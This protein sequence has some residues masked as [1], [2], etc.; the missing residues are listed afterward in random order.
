MQAPKPALPEG[1]PPQS[2]RGA[3][4]AASGEGGDA[5]A[6]RA[7]LE[8]Q[9][10][11]ALQRQATEAGLDPKDIEDAEESDSPKEAFVELLVEW[12]KR[13]EEEEEE[14]TTGTPPPPP[15]A[16]AAAAAAAAPAAPAPAAAAPAPAPGSGPAAVEEVAAA[17]AVRNGLELLV[18]SGDSKTYA[19]TQMEVALT[20]IAELAPQQDW[21][22]LVTREGI[23]EHLLA[24]VQEGKGWNGV[25]G[26]KAP[27]EN[28][29]IRF[30]NMTDHDLTCEVLEEDGRVMV[31]KHNG[32]P[33]TLTARPFSAA[34]SQ[35]KAKSCVWTSSQLS[36]PGTRYR[37]SAGSFSEDHRVDGSSSQSIIV[38]EKSAESLY[39]VSSKPG[40]QLGKTQVW[41]MVRIQLQIDG[42][43]ASR[44]PDEWIDSLF[45]RYDA[46]N[47]GLIDDDEW[48]SM[49]QQL[50]GEVTRAFP[51]L[52]PSAERQVR[53]HKP[54]EDEHDEV[55]AEEPAGAGQAQKGSQASEP[56]PEPAS[57][58]DD[59]ELTTGIQ[60]W[61]GT[62]PIIQVYNK[63][64]QQHESPITN[65]TF[66][67]RTA[68]LTFDVRFYHEKKLSTQHYT[69]GP[70]EKSEP[71]KTFPKAQWNVRSTDGSASHDFEIAAEDG[72]G[73]TICVIEMA[74][75]ACVIGVSA[76]DSEKDLYEPKDV[77]A[78]LTNIETAPG[79]VAARVVLAELTHLVAYPTPIQQNATLN[80][81]NLSSEP[82]H[83]RV[84]DSHGKPTLPNGSG[85]KENT[86]QVP[87]RTGDDPLY[88]PGNPDCCS[89]SFCYAD[90]FRGFNLILR[91]GA[92]ELV[93]PLSG[94]TIQHFFVTEGAPTA[95][96]PSEILHDPAG[97]KPSVDDDSE[98]EGR[99]DPDANPD[100]E[101]RFFFVLPDVWRGLVGDNKKNKVLGVEL[102]ALNA[103]PL[104]L[105][106][107]PCNGI[108]HLWQSDP[109]KQGEWP[110]T[111]AGQPCKYRYRCRLSIST[112]GKINR[113]MQ[114][115]ELEETGGR[116]WR[117]A[118][119]RQFDVP[120]T[121]RSPEARQYAVRACM[122][123]VVSIAQGDDDTALTDA[124]HSLHELYTCFGMIRGQKKGMNEYY[125]S[126]QMPIMT[127][128]SNMLRPVGPEYAAAWADLIWNK[129]KA[130]GVSDTTMMFFL[131]AALLIK[132]ANHTVAED[133]I[134]LAT[135]IA[136]ALKDFS[137]LYSRFPES[138]K[139]P[140]ERQLHRYLSARGTTG[141]MGLLVDFQ[142]A[143]LHFKD[144]KYQQLSSD[145]VGRICPKDPASTGDLQYYKYALAWAKVADKRTEGATTPAVLRL[146]ADLATSYKSLKFLL[147]HTASLD[148]LYDV[149]CARMIQLLRDDEKIRLSIAA[150]ELAELQAGVLD[151]RLQHGIA[152]TLEHRLR[153][154]DKFRPRHHN[155]A[156]LTRTSTGQALVNVIADASWA[157]TTRILDHA[158]VRQIH[159]NLLVSISASRNS[160]V[161]DTLLKVLSA[162]TFTSLTPISRRE[163]CESW[164]ATAVF[165][166][167]WAG[168]NRRQDLLAVYRRLGEIRPR[169]DD[170]VAQH[171][172]S[173]A[174]KITVG[175]YSHSQYHGEQHQ[176]GIQPL[177]CFKHCSEIN[178]MLLQAA[179]SDDLLVH[180]SELYRTLI[181]AK[182]AD[183][184]T[185][186]EA[187]DVISALCGRGQVVPSELAG[188]CV[189][190]LLNSIAA[191][192]FGIHIPSPSKGEEREPWQAVLTA[193]GFWLRLMSLAGDNTAEIN[194]HPEMVRARGALQELAE[195]AEHS[196]LTI[197]T[198]RDLLGFHGV[199]K[200]ASP[201]AME[202][203]VTYK[204]VALNVDKEA[205]MKLWEIRSLIREREL[206]YKQLAHVFKHVFL[207]TQCITDAGSLST[208]LNKRKK[209]LEKQTIDEVRAGSYWCF[210]E[211]VDF[212]PIHTGVSD[213][214]RNIITLA[215]LCALSGFNGVPESQTFRRLCTH[216]RDAPQATV[217][218]F[219]E[220]VF[221]GIVAEYTTHAQSFATREYDGAVAKL[222]D[223]D[224]MWD[225]LTFGR[226]AAKSFTV[227]QVVEVEMGHLE[228]FIDGTFHPDALVHM[229]SYAD[230][231]N[232]Q[233]DNRAEHLRATTD[234]F[235]SELQDKKSELTDALDILL[236][237][238]KDRSKTLVA[239]HD[240]LET[241]KKQHLDEKLW[242]LVAEL[243][244]ATELVAFLRQLSD[245]QDDVRALIDGVEEHSYDQF[246]ANEKTV[247]NFI[248]VSTFMRPLL[249]DRKYTAEHLRGKTVKELQSMWKLEQ[250]Q[251]NLTRE[252]TGISKKESQSKEALMAELLTLKSKFKNVE[253]FLQTLIREYENVGAK[254]DAHVLVKDCAT[255]CHALRRL[256]T[257]LANRGEATKETVRNV[258]ERGIFKIGVALC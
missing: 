212:T 15:P 165:Q 247:K 130:V 25:E 118:L 129:S 74:K 203:S 56:A 107:S 236:G 241:V 179:L 54:L 226:G 30:W 17:D 163:I 173:I 128:R 228:K 199:E 231:K 184:G 158:S 58:P 81:W 192:E 27:Y 153:R 171:L 66:A 139:D 249:L 229:Q 62:G 13:K 51:D 122:E 175:Q 8:A 168:G 46:D 24:L 169:V 99:T 36:Q 34:D 111:S 112:G 120:R 209:N 90:G 254:V 213:S 207:N 189:C 124:L 64:R 12:R 172:D 154:Q 41:H 82:L 190:I 255:N 47:S 7:S 182:I 71:V 103:Q 60:V 246:A 45:E 48:E 18:F 161:H 256:Y 77:A 176:H 40:K 42:I 29:G 250:S 73:Q 1:Q 37:I 57:Q 151:K 68:D 202:G 121:D 92:G 59:Q 220:T 141:S 101:L 193:G 145:V 109:I 87:N 49:A 115:Q 116:L 93:R 65:L 79:P 235:E 219:M 98:H 131:V 252:Y 61:R 215:Q 150:Q 232:N 137:R 240:S 35:V 227:Q 196:R 143:R 225:E 53:K 188:N 200:M 126:T 44:I 211:D 162:E 3:D 223:L 26:E 135:I 186:K 4:G 63:T 108:E 67:N 75:H 204:L 216:R 159:K 33:L 84:E 149:T 21:R 38:R 140:V 70:G 5:D 243:A 72:S 102:Y 218:V 230:V 166:H 221:P 160:E 217:K 52:S 181:R 105:P 178:T 237:T 201:L 20:K 214:R 106:L 127:D 205:Y 233:Y 95:F 174:L 183:L 234:I 32:K 258:V 39:S 164:F 50:A 251:G 69:V 19:T 206:E 198:C 239:L 114:E 142:I 157:L 83:V 222:S 244:S 238:Q 11:K 14:A 156:E 125:A 28:R 180:V 187:N 138:V 132:D 100:R 110:K 134:L 224:R 167:E 191:G 104:K 136:S 94:G 257:N 208:E 147:E 91:S 197:S 253:E 117:P 210:S 248:S 43:D 10:W 89:Y 177:D 76:I 133:T 146:M 195:A 152:G 97:A 6:Y 148:E 86:I 22:S 85:G 55:V 245:N 194:K 123:L 78:A 242:Q 144:P 88:S 113:K 2:A 96:D 31:D 119:Q 9:K 185:E 80:V 23:S 16:A 170:S 155:T